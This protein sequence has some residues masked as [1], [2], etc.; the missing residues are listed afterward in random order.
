MKNNRS[1][2]DKKNNPLKVGDLVL[3][4][5]G[6]VAKIKKI[7]PYTG[8]NFALLVEWNKE[9]SNEGWAMYGTHLWADNVTRF[10]GDK[11]VIDERNE[12]AG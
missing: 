7:Q 11:K 12:V 5:L 2:L 10:E 9:D 6:Y 1:V 4:T 8:G 3:T